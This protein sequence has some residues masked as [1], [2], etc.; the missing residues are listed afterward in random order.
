[1]ISTARGLIILLVAITVTAA[2][3][4]WYENKKAQDE[5]APSVLFPAIALTSKEVKRSA[6]EETP[7]N[8]QTWQEYKNA[9]YGFTVKHPNGWTVG[10]YKQDPANYDRVFFNPFHTSEPPFSGVLMQIASGKSF[11]QEERFAFGN[12]DP[13][14]VLRE[15]T[16]DLAGHRSFWVE[17]PQGRVDVFVEAAGA[18]YVISLFPNE[19]SLTRSEFDYLVSTLT[20]GE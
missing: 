2:S 7:F 15:T 19:N 18:T 14:T 20:F 6:A 3:V 17:R 1:M 9:G 12:A 16:P 5:A 13:A 8:A 11:T 4:L 10:E